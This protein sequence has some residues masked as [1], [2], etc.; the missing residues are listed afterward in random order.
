[1][2]VGFARSRGAH[3]AY[4]TFGEG[5]PDLLWLSTLTVPLDSFEDEPHTA[6]YLRRLASFARVIR[7][8]WRGVGSSDPPESTAVHEI[9]DMAADALAVLDAAG[10]ERAVVLAET[11]GGVVGLQL[12]VDA[13]E[14]VASLVLASCYA[15][16]A[17]A[18]DY[19]IGLR[20]EL[21][22]AFLRD[23][24]NPDVEWTVGGEG[25]LGLT[26]PS[27]RSDP[28]FVEWW[29]R[30]S[31]RGASPVRAR[32]LLAMTVRADQRSV[33]P[34]IT[35]PT[36]VL[37]R[38]GD[39]FVPARFGAYLAEHIPG[40]RY[41]ELPG[42][43]HLAFSGDA[44]ALLDEIEEFLTGHR[45]GSADRVLATIL[46]TDIVDSTGRAAAI[47]D[48][49]WRAELDAHDLLVRTQLGRFGG[50][51]VKT[52]G[53]GF[54][55]TFDAPSAAIPAAVAIARASRAAGLPI[56][57]G[58]HTGECERRGDDLAG[59]AVHIAARVAALAGAGE[60]WASRT[61]RDALVGSAVTFSSRG[62]HELRGV[63]LQWELF[64]I[65]AE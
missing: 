27:L 59:L 28:R 25:D 6:R 17:R 4:T 38:E 10:S 46:V 41:V 19:R 57:A 43:D 55:A 20:P 22:D 34:A 63:P 50:R 54:V 35:Q 52:T 30:A 31:R 8:D 32:Q 40:A 12:A 49:A 5:P 26:A 56:R 23:N 61:V 13:P 24:P 1:V 29:H 51:E 42:A 7:F 39:V 36:L 11:G 65:E 60:V 2:D 53:D 64:A 62:E 48:G 58:I 21:L 9:A 45:H 16:L 18:D 44:D 14:R 47:G 33:L 3:V 37:H 15:R